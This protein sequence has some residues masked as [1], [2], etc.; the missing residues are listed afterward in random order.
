M[1]ELTGGLVLEGKYSFSIE[2]IQDM[3]TAA[4]LVN[5]DSENEKFLRTSSTW[6]DPV[7][8]EELDSVG[9]ELRRQDLKIN[10]LMDM[11]SEL[12]MRQSELPPPESIKLTPKGIEFSNKDRQLKTGTLGKVFLYILPA[13]PRALQFYGEVQS[14]EQEGS[15]RLEFSGTGKAVQDQIDKLLF[16]HHRRSIAQVHA[17]IKQ[18]NA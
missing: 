12:L 8:V 17:G 10:L 9:L 1:A 6:Q 2:T 3:P 4:E 7:E 14:G 13:L 18:A 16:T 15:L 11:V 5:I